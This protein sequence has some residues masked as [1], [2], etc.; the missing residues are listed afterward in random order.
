MQ[1]GDS[2]LRKFTVENFKSFRDTITLDFTA[3]KKFEFNER[4]I[5]N[6]IINKMLIYGKNA[7]GKTNL[8]LAILDICCVLSDYKRAI[9]PTRAYNDFIN[10]EKIK[11]FATFI[12]EFQFND[13]IVI[14]KYH[15]K[16]S[17]ELLYEELII[18]DKVVVK[19]N[20]ATKKRFID[21]P[22]ASTLKYES[23]ENNDIPFS[24]V[25][26]IAN[27]TIFEKN[28]PINLLMDF[29]PRIIW[30]NTFRDDVSKGPT[31]GS[32]I[33][34][35]H[36]L[37][38]N[39]VSELEDYLNSNGIDCKLDF[40][41][42]NNKKILAFNYNGNK[43]NFFEN[44]SSGTND[45]V[46]LYF[47]TSQFKSLRFIFIDEFDAF[48]HY[49]LAY[50]I[51]QSLLTLDNIQIVITT[52]NTY[53]IDNNLMRPDCYY[54]IANNEIKNFPQSTLKEIRE[55]HNLEKMYRNGEFE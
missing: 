23:L 5:K 34:S 54:L 33:I 39:S 1:L 44:A 36:F 17:D 53:L 20:F 7:S 37:K 4:L 16:S 3:V 27:N 30:G 13:D 42:S 15:K 38:N 26:Y 18:N 51:V 35:E 49:E 47:W 48:Y 10:A 2:M 32:A 43:I 40:M 9:L 19:Y 46:W 21:L 6:G 41:E 25:K 50:K 22:E 28:H 45:L 14:Y 31:I 11:D 24:I 12:Y 55:A 29:V 8:G 52:H